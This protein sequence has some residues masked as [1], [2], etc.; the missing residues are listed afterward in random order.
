MFSNLV[1]FIFPG[2]Q[3]RPARATVT[4][5]PEICYYSGYIRNRLVWKKYNGK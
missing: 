5:H 4:L 2:S 3:P 1:A